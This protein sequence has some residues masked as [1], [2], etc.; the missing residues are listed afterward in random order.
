MQ[1]LLAQAEGLPDPQ[2]GPG[3]QRDEEAVPCSGRIR[4]HA[5]DLLR[6][7]V[8]VAGLAVLETESR[9]LGLAP[10][11]A[12]AGVVTGRQEPQELR[13]LSNAIFVWTA[14]GSS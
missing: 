1:I 12:L 14:G 8:L 2:A 5:A 10:L 3:E 9:H 7:K 4:D 6:G 11:A 13:L